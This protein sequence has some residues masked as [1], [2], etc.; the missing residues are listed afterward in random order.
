MP[1]PRAASVGASMNSRMKNSPA[2]KYSRKKG[3][4]SIHTIRSPAAK[5]ARTRSFCP[6]PMFC[7]V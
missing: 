6:A 7:A 5:P 1:L 2:K 4:Q 3:T